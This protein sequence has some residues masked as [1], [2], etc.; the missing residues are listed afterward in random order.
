[1]AGQRRTTWNLSWTVTAGFVGGV[2]AYLAGFA[3]IYLRKA[4]TLPDDGLGTIGELSGIGAMIDLPSTWQVVGWL[5]YAAHNV[6]IVMAVSG[7]GRSGM[8]TL[9]LTEGILWERWFALLPVVTLLTVGFSLA[10]LASVPDVWRGFLS[11]S[12]IALGYA[13][14]A[15]AGVIV[16]TWNL[17]ISYGGLSANGAIRPD[18][19]GSVLLVGVLYPVVLGGVGG[20]IASVIDGRRDID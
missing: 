7:L 8:G 2:I 16:T 5:Y 12:S 1:M 18:P 9:P 11:G 19:F 3:V 10:F 15:V 14:I 20:A 4:G 17:S 6:D 13:P